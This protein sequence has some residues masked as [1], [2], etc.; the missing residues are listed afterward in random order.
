MLRWKS[1]TARWVSGAEDPVDPGDREPELL[2]L[3]LQRQDVVTG[4]RVRDDVRQQPVA[5]PPA[6]VVDRPVR[7]RAD[8]PVDHQPALL[9]EPP[10]SVRGRFVVDVVTAGQQPEPLELADD[11]GDGLTA[12]ADPVHAVGGFH[13]DCSL[14][15]RRRCLT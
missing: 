6:R 9:L 7:L 1:V 11:L 8:D 14:P 5:Q 12:V 10:D 3:R 13:Q 2:Q 15:W 4:Q